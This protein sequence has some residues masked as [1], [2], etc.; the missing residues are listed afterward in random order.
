M[1]AASVAAIEGAALL[2]NAAV[3]L[4]VVIRDGITGP[5]PVASPVGVTV[6][7]ALYLAFGAA[8]LWIARGIVRGSSA[9][10]TPFALAQ[11]L[12]L[13]VSIPLATAAGTA[14]VFGW[15]LTALCLLGLIAWVGLLRRQ[16]PA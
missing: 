16:A 9:V 14:A 15:L 7:I 13:T 3:V 12:G 10:N 1:V 11:V 8:M 2:G 4:W 6:E 5:A